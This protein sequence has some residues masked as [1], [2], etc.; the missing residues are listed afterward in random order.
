MANLE[1]VSMRE[2]RIRYIILISI[3]CFFSIITFWIQYKN[4]LRHTNVDISKIPL[5]IGEWQGKEIPIDKKISAILETSSILMREYSNGKDS[6]DLAIV[7][8]KDSRVALHLPESCYTGQG[9]H[10][11]KRETEEISTLGLKDFYA[12][13]LLLKGNKGN[14]VILYY[15]ET[16]SMRTNSYLA[17]RWQMILNKLNSK[18]TSGALVRFSTVTTE[19][20]IANNLE[21]LKKFIREIGSLL[22]NYLI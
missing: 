9:S 15:F 14:Q 6:V 21:I 18:R 4:P 11:V 3:F 8:Y 7:Y 20:S 1:E 22:P 5:N 2:F 16:G 13:K 12:N 19:N 17:L 10:I